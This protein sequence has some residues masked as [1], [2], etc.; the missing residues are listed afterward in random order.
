MSPF[1]CSTHRALFTPFGGDGECVSSPNLSQIRETASRK[2]HNLEVV[3]S[4]PASATI[5][6]LAVLE[7]SLYSHRHFSACHTQV[8]FLPPCSSIPS[9]LAICGGFCIITL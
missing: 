4:T 6:A 9:Q 7:S 2:A 3:G 5:Q 1:F 8:R